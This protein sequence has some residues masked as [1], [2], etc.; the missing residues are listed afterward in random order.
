MLPNKLKLIALLANCIFISSC[1]GQKNRNQRQNTSN[2]EQSIASNESIKNNKRIEQISEVV[3]MMFQDS[4]GRIWFGAQGGAFKLIENEL[5]FIEDIKSETGKSTYHSINDLKESADVLL[6]SERTFEIKK[7]LRQL[8]FSVL[9]FNLED[10]EVIFKSLK[11]QLEYLTNETALFNKIAAK[12]QNN[13]LNAVQKRTLFE[14]MATWKSV[15]KALFKDLELFSNKYEQ[16]TSLKELIGATVSVE[17]W[18]EDFKIHPDEDFEALQQDATHA[19][20]W[21]KNPVTRVLLVFVL[22]NLGSA[23]ATWISGF[24]IFNQLI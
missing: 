21:W 14:Q 8:G 2:P 9:E 12:T 20:G 17:A 7:I 3:R 6:I 13:V 18:L 11:T 19:K 22:T 5:I 16:T 15:N 24:K 1:D 10:Y 23:L 4:K